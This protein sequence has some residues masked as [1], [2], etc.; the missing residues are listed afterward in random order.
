MI[1]TLDDKIVLITVT[2]W[3]EIRRESELIVSHGLG[4]NTMRV[5][6]MPCEHPKRMGGVWDVDLQEW[7][8]NIDPMDHW[9]RLAK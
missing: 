6:I 3:N 5:H 9:G 4:N 7:V 8:I 1:D 2:E